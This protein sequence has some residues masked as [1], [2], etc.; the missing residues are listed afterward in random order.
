MCFAI[1]EI[2]NLD[3]GVVERE[4]GLQTEKPRNG[5]LGGKKVW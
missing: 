4:I 2:W 5:Q 3:G 1:S